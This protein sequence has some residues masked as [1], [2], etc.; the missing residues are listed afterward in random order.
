[1]TA[2]MAKLAARAM[3]PVMAREASARRPPPRRRPA[4]SRLLQ[5]AHDDML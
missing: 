1:M 2:S 5:I 4:A 3:P